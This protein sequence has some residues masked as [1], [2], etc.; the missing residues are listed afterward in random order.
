MKYQVEVLIERKRDDVVAAYLDIDMMKK[1]EK[2]L[3]DI[4]SVKGSL[5]EEGS[6]GYLHFS[7]G[8]QTMKMKVTNEKITIPE[9]IIQIYE[10]PGAWNRCD[11]HFIDQNGHTLW[12]MDVEFRFAED[13]NLPIERFIEQTKAGMVLFKDFMMGLGDA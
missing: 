13:P 9:Q 2:G 7:F 6:E 10:V 5:F 12:I 1:W 8:D 4:E 3:T 11:N